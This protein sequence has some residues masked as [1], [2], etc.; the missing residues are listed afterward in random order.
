M[1]RSQI[2][3]FKELP[4]SD[5]KGTQEVGFEMHLWQKW[6]IDGSRWPGSRYA[7]RISSFSLSR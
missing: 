2:V 7:T 6:P 5:Q 1:C 4:V 3:G